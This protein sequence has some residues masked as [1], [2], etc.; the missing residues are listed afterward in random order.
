MRKQ[1][2]AELDKKLREPNVNLQE[3][4]NLMCYGDDL[5]PNYTD[6]TTR[7]TTAHRSAY[8][9]EADLLKWC[10]DF[11]EDINARTSLGRSLLHYACNGNR[12]RCIRLLLDRGADANLPSLSGQTPLH[13]CCMYNCYEAALELLH[14]SQQVVDVDCEDTRRLSPEQCTDNKLLVRAIRKYRAGLQERRKADLI[15]Q[16]LKRIFTLSSSTSG[17]S[18][19]GLQVESTWEEFRDAHMSLIGPSSGDEARTLLQQL[20]EL[21]QAIFHDF[22][23]GDAD[24]HKEAT[25]RS[26]D[27]AGRRASRPLLLGAHSI[28]G[29]STIDPKA[30]QLAPQRAAQAGG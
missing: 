12:T 1:L 24:G 5:N 2:Q 14:G 25:P 3:V 17:K 6:Y 22:V 30:S 4:R 11:G 18:K 10:L 9:G 13:I 28:I 8:E 27:T 16:T 19:G 15:E 23:H 21:E 20:Y 7:M 26:R 29:M